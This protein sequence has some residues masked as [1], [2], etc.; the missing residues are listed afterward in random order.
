MWDLNTEMQRASM[1]HLVFLAE[2]SFLLHKVCSCLEQT[3]EPSVH[4]TTH[5]AAHLGTLCDQGHLLEQLTPLS[6]S[7]NVCEDDQ[8]VHALVIRQ[9]L[10]CCQHKSWGDESLNGGV[11]GQVQEQDSSLHGAILLKV[12][13]KCKIQQWSG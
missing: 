4:A 9:V 1:K 7:A 13:C 5:S 3:A 2:N 11:I 8:H 12:L 6:A 10:S